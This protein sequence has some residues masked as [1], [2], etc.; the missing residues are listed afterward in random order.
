MRITNYQDLA[1]EKSNE[2]QTI[3]LRVST[4]AKMEIVVFVPSHEEMKHF[5]IK[6]T[7]EILKKIS[8][9]SMID[10]SGE[11]DYINVQKLIRNK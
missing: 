11:L 1:Q 10:Y 8:D 5:L 6:F 9:E 3:Y 4:A 7:P 2:N